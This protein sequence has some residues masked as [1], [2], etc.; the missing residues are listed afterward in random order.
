MQVLIKNVKDFGTCN[1][2]GTHQVIEDERD[3]ENAAHNADRDQFDRIIFYV[4][5]PPNWMTNHDFRSLVRAAVAVKDQFHGSRMLSEDQISA[6]AYESDYAIV[7]L[8]TIDGEEDPHFGTCDVTGEA[9]NVFNAVAIDK[10]GNQWDLQ[11][12]HGVL[13]YFANGID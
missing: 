9:G 8:C 12:L 13:C 7:A 10:E 5:Y 2:Q 11:C 3:I 4:S 1:L 6:I